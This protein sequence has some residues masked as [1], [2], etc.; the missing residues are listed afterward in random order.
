[1][2]SSNSEPQEQGVENTQH[3]PSDTP[4]AQPAHPSA[5]QSVEGQ[6]GFSARD[7]T[8]DEHPADIT[9]FRVPTFNVH[10]FT[11]RARIESQQTTKSSS[12]L[13]KIGWPLAE[14]QRLIEAETHPLPQVEVVGASSLQKIAIFPKWL[15]GIVV[16]LF[17]GATLALQALNLFNYP[18]YTSDEGNYMA[19]AWAVLQGKL[20]AYTFTYTH[21]PL[22]WIQI[23]AWTDLTGGITSFGNAIN[24]GRVMMLMLAT[25]SALLLYLIARQLTRSRSAG[26]L[27]LV[28]YTLSPLSLLYRHEVLLDNVGIFWLL[29]SLYLIT[30]GKSRLGTIVLAALALAIAILSK[31]VFLIFL[32][33]MVF[34]VWLY[35]TRFQRKF[36]LVTFLYIVLGLASLYVLFALLKGELFPTGTVFGGTAA[37]PSLLGTL[38]QTFQ[39]PGPQAQF[40]ESWQ[41]WV[42]TDWIILLAGMVAMFINLL[43]GIANR[44]Q[45]LAAL[46]VGTFCLFLL[47]SSVVYPFAIIPLL[48]FLALNIALALD[49]LLV[50]L[51]VGRRFDLARALLILVLIGAL[52]AVNTQRSRALVV[53]NQTQSQQEAM[54]WVRDYVSHQ[55]EV[56]TNSY[57][58]T[59]LHDPQEVGMSDTQP[60]IHAQIYT[61]AA[62]DPAITVGE[63]KQ[64]WQKID[65]LVV[66]TS[67][68][69]TIQLDKR[70]LLLNEA[71]EHAVLRAD[72]GSSANGTLI[73]VYQVVHS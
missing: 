25:A 51:T 27:A 15:E 37:H 59:D 31:G 33:T 63:L 8:L 49:S 17:L 9:L 14:K 69:Q 30:N 68:L 19:N 12:F 39:A 72:F 7:A 52:V 36:S 50:W 47:T 32:P 45:L 5:P 70:Y 21:P 29:L 64:D 20:T 46:F 3:T 16:A 55:A 35:A 4:L 65:F 56:I 23:A 24:S 44:L 48:P 41:T 43:G 60:F 71:L 18:S 28:I 42:Q 53:Q 22:G 66:D 13:K 54:W 57:F 73:E 67:M 2:G 26:L 62:L 10:A 6:P 58:Y 11:S 61:D 34:A 38:L 1:M 40:R